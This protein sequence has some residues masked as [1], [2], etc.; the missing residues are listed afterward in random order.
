LTRRAKDWWIPGRSRDRIDFHVDRCDASGVAGWAWRP[1]TPGERLDLEVLVDG[2]A[3]GSIRAAAFRPDLV[4][5]AKDDGWCAFDAPLPPEARDGGPHAIGLRVR[6]DAT[7]FFSA[8]AATYATPRVEI[9]RLG[10]GAVEGRAWIEGG[11]AGDPEI[12]IEIDGAVVAR[13]RPDRDRRF[14][15]R[16]RPP[17]C[18]PAAADIAVRALVAGREIAAARFPVLRG[19]EGRLAIALD[20]ADGSRIGGWVLTEP[21]VRRLTLAADGVA[22]AVVESDET[23]AF[24]Q[25]LAPLRLADGPRRLSLTHEGD[26]CTIDLDYRRYDVRADMVASRLEI[27]LVDRWA[28]P[29]PTPVEVL[30]DGEPVA[31]LQLRPAPGDPEAP[32]AASFALGRR[33]GDGREHVATLRGPGDAALDARAIVFRVEPPPEAVNLRVE[34]DAAGAATGWAYRLLGAGPPLEVELWREGVRIGSGLADR[35][36]PRLAAHGLLPVDAGFAF[37]LGATPPGACLLRVRDGGRTVAERAFAWPPPGIEDGGVGR[38]GTCIV[39][40]DPAADAAAREDA[41]ELLALAAALDRPPAAIALPTGA[42]TPGPGWIAALIGDAAAARLATTPVIRTPAAPAPTTATGRQ[43]QA[44]ALDLWARSNAFDRLIG[45][46]RDG[47]LA[48]CAAARRQGLGLSGT[49]L[50]VLAHGFCALDRL[51]SGGLIDDPDLLFGEAL[52]RAALQGA[53]VVLAF[54]EALA[55]RAGAVAPGVATAIAPLPPLS[56]PAAPTPPRRASGRWLLF[57]GPLRAASGL[58]EACDALDR[59]AEAAERPDGVAFIGPE[60]LV[61]DMAAGAYL[62]GRSGRWPFE[63]RIH[64]DLDH[65]GMVW[66]ARG[67]EAAAAILPPCL[68]GGPWAGLAAALG[69]ATVGAASAGGHPGALAAALAAALAQRS[70]PSGPPT[71]PPPT[72]ALPAAPPPA[73][74]PGPLAGLVSVCVTHFNRP[75]LL[76]QAL[77]SIEACGD[78]ESEIVVVDD[79]STLPEAQEALKEVETWLGARG[80]RLVRQANAYLGAARNAA[81]RAA[82]GDLLVFMDDDNLAGPTML[83]DMRAILGRT[84]ADLVTCRFGH[85]EAGDLVDPGR[86]APTGF[87]VPLAPDLGAG[88]LS[89]CF[90]DANMMIRRTAFERIGGFTED[91]GRGH[92]DWELMARAATLGLRHEIAAKA[93]F[94]YRISPTGMLRGRSRDEIDLQRNIRAYAH[95]LPPGL[96]RTLQLAQGLCRRWGA[97]PAPRHG[98]A[99]PVLRTTRRLAWGRVAVVMRTK[100]RPLLLGRAIDSVLAQTYGDWALAIVNDGGDPAPVE[101]IVE[102]RRRA[103]AGRCL[104]LSNPRPTGMENASNLALSQSTS[105]FVVVHDDDDSWAPTFL[106]RCVAHLDAAPVETGGV[107][108]HAT[109]IVEEI[110]EGTVREVSR[111]LFRDLESVQIARLARENEFPPISFLFRRSAMEAVGRFDGT[112]PVLGDWDFH[113]RVAL[114]FPIEVLREPLAFYHHRREGGDYGNTVIA[115]RASHRRMR[116]AYLDRA[117]REA[118]AAGHPLGALLFAADAARIAEAEADRSREH[119]HWLQKLLEDRGEHMAYLE[120]LILNGSRRP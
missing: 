68:A 63:V 109:V 106:E 93:L 115:G 120:K 78:R 94:W 32:R 43:A 55:A 42:A 103:L 12:E 16:G 64:A 79:G 14:R 18:G 72:M 87:S 81:A 66:A 114:R 97:A 5:A 30:V 23:G 90:G 11:R 52:E 95:D 85:F 10:P 108:T 58:I 57:L 86:D 4:A 39:L 41:R 111:H 98:P 69:L 67:F 83:K 1:S 24:E 8:A 77:R 119:T 60:D 36:H 20:A 113:L 62:R 70:G 80:G 105:E 7:A 88:V 13:S 104:L 112:L 3:C 65:E 49:A 73:A 50:F 15:W 44:V 6:G 53:D 28:S 56:P 31:L 45:P 2:A 117:L 40:P 82:R 54:N 75:T 61:H 25:P 89:N 9:E 76:W 59:L 38:A 110:V 102:A 84:G 99:R 17:A 19:A 118:V 47:P 107:V 27:E 101:R 26:A 116:A 22:L 29:T 21:A 34:V 33:W 96:Y 51:G 37:D 74:A 35:A 48:Y 92:E 46:S 71:T 100:D 91:W